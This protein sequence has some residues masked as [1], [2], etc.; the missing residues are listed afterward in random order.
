M[1][2]HKEQKGIGSFLLLCL[3]C[4]GVVFGDIGTSPLYTMGEMFYPEEGHGVPIDKESVIGATSAMLWSLYLIVGICYC[5]FA[6]SADHHGEGGVLALYA[7][8]GTGV[9]GLLLILGTGLLIGDGA[10]TPPISI[11]GGLEGLQ[12][13]S[14]VFKP[15]IVP[16][17]LVI[18]TILFGFQ[19]KGTAV[20]GLAFGPIMLAWFIAI[21]AIGLALIEC[22]PEI[23]RALNPLEGIKFLI[24][25]GSISVKIHFLGSAML[26]ITGGEALYADLGHFT[27]RSIQVSFAFV[28]VC[29]TTNYLGQGAFIISGHKV[30]E[31]N[32]FYSSIKWLIGDVGLCAMIILGTNSAIIAS[33]ALI[34]GLF[35][36]V[37]MAMAMKL[38]C[39]VETL[40]TSDHHKG[41]I[42]QP[43]TNKILYLAC[44]AIVLIFQNTKNL[45]SA[46]GLAVASLMLITCYA[47]EKV[48]RLLWNWSW[49]KS[50][51]V[52]VP[53]AIIEL[54]F[55]IAN[56]FK[57][58]QGGY[59]PFTIGIFVFALM[60]TWQWGEKSIGQ[61]MSI[62]CRD[63]D[64]SWLIAIKDQMMDLKLALQER[65]LFAAQLVRGKQSKTEFD[66]NGAYLVSR[67]ITTLTDFLPSSLLAFIQQWGALPN[68][69]LF[70]HT[71]IN[72]DV[73]RLGEN[74]DKAQVFDFGS[75]V[76]SIVLHYGFRET[77]YIDIAQEINNLYQQDKLPVPASQWQF[78]VG[79][80]ELIAD[81]NLS[82]FDKK[83]LSFVKFLRKLS[84]PAHHYFGLAGHPAVTKVLVPILFSKTGTEVCLPNLELSINKSTINSNSVESAVTLAK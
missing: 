12:V 50:L 60:T 76:W 16:L 63:K 44:V 10:I 48:A 40:C 33:Q 74:V 52:F 53:F 42:Y 83:R 78:V 58:F 13:A 20:I 72:P 29:L 79:E 8:V 57:F 18:L 67:P 75:N 4:L 21:G 26:A 38:M 3:M 59:Y 64:V 1:S 39:R 54:A 28:V 51:A 73:A 70:V 43:A 15:W 69:I 19:Y 17:A 25:G 9:T 55:L 81:K 35:S 45:G 68:R 2:Q 49:P 23:L 80:E 46:Y 84:I 24:G 71:H 32:V 6:L 36:L 62:F 22:Q 31:G 56:G 61:A 34:T 66:R 65:L 47:L 14:P 5:M 7:L 41:Q 77:Q 11:L 30:I 27:K 37:A 82:W